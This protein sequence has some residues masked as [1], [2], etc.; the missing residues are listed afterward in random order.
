MFET[1]DPVGSALVSS[2]AKPG[3]N[4]TGVAQL[5]SPELFGKQLE[6]LKEMVPNLSRVGLL[7][8][9]VRDGAAEGRQVPVRANFKTR[10]S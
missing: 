9:A 8:T 3:G 1:A 2:L 7:F 10:R 6:I 4:I 5:I